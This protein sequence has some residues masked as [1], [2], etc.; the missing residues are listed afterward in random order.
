MWKTKLVE[1]EFGNSPRGAL[2]MQPCVM[3]PHAIWSNSFHHFTRA[4]WDLISNVTY[5]FGVCHWKFGVCHWKR[6]PW[7]LGLNLY[8]LVK[9]ILSRVRVRCR[10]W[11]YQ[12]ILK[13]QSASSTWIFFCGGRK[14]LIFALM[15]SLFPIPG[16]WNTPDRTSTLTVPPDLFNNTFGEH[17]IHH[18]P[19]CLQSLQGIR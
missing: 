15:L 19:H 17:I 7:L 11:V 4:W 5:V 8:Y 9:H 12:P 18:G 6:H 2:L 10:N 14:I 1:G 16:K 3:G 13:V